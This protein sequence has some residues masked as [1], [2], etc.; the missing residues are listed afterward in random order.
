MQRFKFVFCSLAGVALMG[1]ATP[2]V[3]L[4]SPALNLA[5]QL[6]E[7]FI[8]VADKVSPAV[9]IVEVTEKPSDTDEDESSWWDLIP[10]EDRPH[11]RFHRHGSSHSRPMMGYGSGVIISPDGYILTNNHVV[12]NT[13]KIEVRF[14][15]GRVY[16]AEIKGTDPESDIAV[17]KIKA[18]GLTPAKLGDSDG[19][20]VGEFV[21]AIGAPFAL[22]YSVTFGH[23]SAKGRFFPEMR[24]FSDQDFIQ[25]DASINPGNSGGPLV[26]LYG[27]VIA[28]NTMIEGENTGIGFAIPINLAKRVKDHLIAE[29]KFTRSWIGIGFDQL[30]DSPAYKQLAPDTESGILVTKIW[31]DSPAAKSDLRTGDVVVSV[32]GKT[33]ETSRELKDAIAPEKPGSVLTLKVVR[34]RE[35]LTIK[36]KTEALPSE[37]ELAGTGH[38]PE[39]EAVEAQTFGLTIQVLTKDLADHY[40]VP[41]GGGV[42]VTEV[43]SDSPANEE[44]IE[45]GDVITQVNRQR[46]G[47]LKQFRQA[48]KAGDAKKGIMVDLISKG[49]NRLVILQDSGR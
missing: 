16:D 28:I 13:E 4:D 6:N 17:I 30:K 48:L 12:E 23:V 20:R 2:V 33:I 8:A 21:L 42:L 9:V 25:T 19:T 10:P 37:E 22:S 36:V 44:G 11:H 5:R 15:D 49:S 1:A 40:G 45:P 38:M 14:K 32:Q 47:S 3:A 24:G 27:E 39:G 35:R 43:E 18:T 41:A 31:A 46:V 34:A 26:N 29:G 7:A